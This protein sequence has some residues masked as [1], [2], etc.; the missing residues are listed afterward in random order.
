MCIVVVRDYSV[1]NLLLY[2][3]T[4]Y[5]DNLSRTGIVRMCRLNVNDLCEPREECFSIILTCN[6]IFER[7]LTYLLDTSS[8]LNCNTLRAQHSKL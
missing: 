4:N 5:H 6:V 3:F 7:G 2:G 1:P 8:I